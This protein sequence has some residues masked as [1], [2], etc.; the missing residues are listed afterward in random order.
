MD[1]NGFCADATALLLKLGSATKKTKE[2]LHNT[3]R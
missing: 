2:K 3:N 1:V